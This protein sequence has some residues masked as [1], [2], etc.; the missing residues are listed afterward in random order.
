MWFVIR[1]KGGR[2]VRVSALVSG[3]NAFLRACEQ[4][5]S[6]DQLMH[7]KAGYAT[8]GRKFPRDKS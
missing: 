2:T 1:A 3:L 7:A 8:L 6:P 5:L 4:Q